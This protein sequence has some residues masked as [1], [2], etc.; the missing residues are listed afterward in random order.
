MVVTLT[1]ETLRALQ[2]AIP[3]YQTI[4]PKHAPEP[5]RPTVCEASLDSMLPDFGDMAE[6]CSRCICLAGMAT[7]VDARNLEGIVLAC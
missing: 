6:I 2:N 4:R 3:I 7:V 5:S 1:E